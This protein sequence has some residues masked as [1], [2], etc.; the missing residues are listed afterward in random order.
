MTVADLL[1]ARSG[2]PST[3]LRA[4][5]EVWSWA[6]VVEAGARRAALFADLRQPGPPHIGVLLGNVPE[7]AFWIGA[8]SLAGAVIVG[9]NPTR[10][11]GEL[12]DDIRHT[13]CQLL[14]TDRAGM[15]LL[16]DVDTGV[17]PDR[18]LV[19]D[20]P[21]YQPLLDSVPGAPLPLPPPTGD[22]LFL[23][24]F[25]SGTTGAPKAVRCSQGRLAAI[26]GRIVDLYHL[27]P[28]DVCY[29]IMPLF[30]GNA[31]MALWIGAV[32]AGSCVALPP[33]GKFSATQFIDDVRL[34]G[35][36]YF[37]DV[38]KALTY[39]LAAPERPDDADNTLTRG[40]GNEA[41]DTDVARFERRFGCRVIEGYGSSEGGAS[42][43][44][45]PNMPPGSLGV[46]PPSIIVANPETGKE[47]PPAR[48]DEGGRLVNGDEA[49]GEIVN[50]AP[51][52]GFEGY[53]NNAEADAERIRDGRY[54]TGDLGYRDAAGFFY[55]AGR[56]ADWLRVDG[57]N[58]AAS[59]VERV[60]H[61][62]RGVVMAAVYAV[63]DAMAGDQVMA[64]LV[65][66]A[67]ELF[68]PAGF[69]E[70][71]AAQSD[72]GTK[73][74]PRFVRISSD[75][76]LTASGKVRKL[77][78]RSEAWEVDDVV[79]WRPDPRSLDYRHFNP[80]DSAA[81]RQ[82]FASHGREQLLPAARE[83]PTVKGWFFCS[84][85][86]EPLPLPGIVEDCP[87][88]GLLLAE[89]VDAF[90]GVL[91]APEYDFDGATPAERRDA[92]GVLL[93]EGIPYRWDSRYQIR[94]GPEHERDVD[95]LFGHD[96]DEAETTKALTVLLEA[97]DRLRRDPDDE[98]GI[99]ELA[100]ATGVVLTGEPPTGVNWVR[101][102]TV[103]YLAR[104][105]VDLVA[106][107]AGL[108]DLAAAADVLHAVLAG[109]G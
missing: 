95:I 102:S 15:A 71:L 31:L 59:P 93:E 70:F 67:G 94:V 39:I 91:G 17:S 77:P 72:L 97:S 73:W 81:V 106:N 84:G 60:L 80:A 7:F 46:G 55:F 21:G 68:S 28:E 109:R 22:S 104:Q 54:W 45:V 107:G 76:P 30:H 99:A 5:E 66:A 19:V 86:G 90:E 3:A 78:L 20:D 26:G 49:I 25:T 38:G 2:D 53:Y 8:A 58:F 96:D 79:W 13:H 24:L 33:T 47:C 69:R 63:P 92:T 16:A 44:R 11:G 48:F 56:G 40:F 32:H 74:A 50:I 23:L 62:Y 4:G 100:D 37:T 14:V 12:S 87:E 34:Y 29:C 18:V 83:I 43:T 64:T 36:T 65:L 35:A 82:Q 89:P 6:E 9:I 75:L 51:S 103:G 85:C 52:T 101:W 42:I 27:V 10:R 105:L 41:S 108:D 61:R 88:C 57:E 98:E 1:L